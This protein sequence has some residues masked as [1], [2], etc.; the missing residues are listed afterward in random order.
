[1]GGWTNEESGDAPVTT[2]TFE[3]QGGRTLLVLSELYGSAEP[4]RDAA[5][6]TQAMM[7]E[8]FD[9]LDQLLASRR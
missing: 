3:D 9:Q 5:A 8:Q 4:L 2:V 7:A 1:M 6:A